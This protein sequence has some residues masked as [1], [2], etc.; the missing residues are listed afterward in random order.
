MDTT[1]EVWCWK[2]YEQ[3][4]FYTIA[5]WTGLSPEKNKFHIWDSASK[6]ATPMARAVMDDFGDLVIVRGWL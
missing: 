4:F 5:I 3:G 2:A 6:S 1:V